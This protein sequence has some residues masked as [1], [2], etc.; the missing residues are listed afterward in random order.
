M[1]FFWEGLLVFLYAFIALSNGTGQAKR[2]AKKTFLINAA[3]DLCLLTGITITGYLAGT[4]NMSEIASNKITL[5]Y[6]WAIF[7]YLLLMTGAVSKAG[8]F[9]FHT[10]IP[11]AASDSNAAFMTVGRIL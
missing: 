8:A 2:T 10:W 6:G 9:P 11:D 5:D 3:T 4:M 1:L 7:A